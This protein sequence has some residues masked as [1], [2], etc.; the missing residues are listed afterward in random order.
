[1]NQ[2]NPAPFRKSICHVVMFEDVSRFAIHFFRFMGSPQRLFAGSLSNQ[3]PNIWLEYKVDSM[4]LKYMTTEDGVQTLWWIEASSHVS[5]D[6]IDALLEIINDC[7]A[8][9]ILDIHGKGGYNP[10]EIREILIQRRSNYQDTTFFISSYNSGFQNEST[11]IFPKT[12][13]TYRYISSKVKKSINIKT[14]VPSSHSHFLITGAGFEMY[15]SKEDFG[16]PSTSEILKSM[17]DPFSKDDFIIDDN[18]RFPLW[19]NY[20]TDYTHKS[21]A[22]TGD[23]DGYWDDILLKSKDRFFDPKIQEPREIQ[24]QKAFE[25]E[26]QLRQAFRKVF[27][28][29]DYGYMNQSILAAAL[30]WKAWITTNYTRFADRAVQLDLS[31]KG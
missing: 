29:L 7:C 3:T 27:L 18:Y 17:D 25:A 31:R 13:Q 10:I 9:F 4:I 28:K 22:E 30:P 8:Y 23:L 21:C 1:M 19:T 16:M 15:S 12:P 20:K 2:T 6:L 24:K 14:T 5:H 26:I 11:P